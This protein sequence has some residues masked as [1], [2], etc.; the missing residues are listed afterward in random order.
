MNK[1]DT[2]VSGFIYQN[3]INGKTKFRDSVKYFHTHYTVVQGWI[4]FSA[5]REYIKVLNLNIGLK[6]YYYYILYRYCNNKFERI[7]VLNRRKIEYY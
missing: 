7:E 4:K 1:R 6:P 2:H 5:L 3:N